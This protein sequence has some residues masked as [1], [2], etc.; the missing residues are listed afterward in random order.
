MARL[1][2]PLARLA[3]AFA[4]SAYGIHLDQSADIAPGFY[5]G[6]LGGIVVRQCHI[7]PHRSISQQVKIGIDTVIPEMS[8]PTEIGSHVWIGA[9]ARLCR[10][11]RVG[12]AATIGA[13][14]WVTCNVP[15]RSLVL[16]NPGRIAQRNYDNGEML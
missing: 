1:L 16:G 3:S 15:A 6:H 5:I 7:G 11:I 9:H 12:D 10:G 4:R 2:R 14:S 8:T 13:G